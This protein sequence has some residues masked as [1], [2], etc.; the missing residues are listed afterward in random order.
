MP[1]FFHVKIGRLRRFFL[2]V[3][4][5]LALAIGATATRPTQAAVCSCPEIAAINSAGW[6]ENIAKWV[7]E[8]ADWLQAFELLNTIIGISSAIYDTSQEIFG[9]MGEKLDTL[10]AMEHTNTALNSE[11]ANTM[12]RDSK[13]AAIDTAINAVKA[14]I[15]ANNFRRP[16]V[17]ADC[18]TTIARQGLSGN[19]I[20]NQTVSNAL[21]QMVETQGIG[22]EEDESGPLG[23]WKRY[24]YMCG[25]LP[26]FPKGM[27]AEME[28]PASCKEEKY[29]GLLTSSRLLSGAYVLEIPDLVDKT[30]NKVTKKVPEPSNDEQRNFVAAAIWLTNVAGFRPS[31]PVGKQIETHQGMVELAQWNHCAAVQSALAKSCADLIAK[32]TRPDC[33]DAN[34]NK[35]K[36]E[37]DAGTRACQAVSASSLPDKGGPAIDLSKMPGFD[38]VKGLSTYQAEYLN[39]LLCFTNDRA[40]ALP[41]QGASPAANIAAADACAVAWDQWQTKMATQQDACTQAAAKM[42]SLTCWPKQNRP[43]IITSN[44]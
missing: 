24:I 37:C 39:H 30:I 36:L 9:L 28:P 42:A 4:F 32:Y 5:L 17:K 1:A 20:F 43:P 21:T 33:S 27:H 13:L 29:A 41:A 40:I 22:R 19:H 34:Y 18:Y 23:A 38:C 44:N 26:G 31:P 15:V 10:I 25:S 7:Q 3:V 35:Y 16:D 14:D 2:P 6:A 8:H 11:I 12:H